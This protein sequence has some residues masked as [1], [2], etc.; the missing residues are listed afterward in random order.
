[1]EAPKNEE[2]IWSCK[3]CNEGAKM[4]YQH[5]V[6]YLFPVTKKNN[7]SEKN[8]EE[9][10]HK[11]LPPKDEEN[12]IKGNEIEEE[13]KNPDEEQGEKAD[14]NNST[15][16]VCENGP[17]RKR[18][19]TQ[20][21]ISIRLLESLTNSNRNEEEEKNPDKREIETSQK[22]RRKITEKGAAFLRG[23]DLYDSK[24]VEG[25]R[26]NRVHNVQVIA[27]LED[28]IVEEDRIE[29]GTTSVCENSVHENQPNVSSLSTEKT[30]G[31][32]KKRKSSDHI[33][34]ETVGIKINLNTCHQCHRNDKGRVVKC[35]KCKMKRFCIPCITTWY[36]GMTEEQIAMSCPICRGNCNCKSCLRNEGPLKNRV[37]DE[38]KISQE[39]K[40]DHSK[41]LL[42]T[43]LPFLK[44]FNQE[45]REEKEIEAKIQGIPVS[46]VKLPHSKFREN[47]RVFCNN[48][49]SS[50]IDFHR[51]CSKCNYNLCV[52]CCRELRA[53]R[54]QFFEEM[55]LENVDYGFQYLHGK[56]STAKPKKSSKGKNAS[57][58]LEGTTKC[59]NANAQSNRSTAVKDALAASKKKYDK[60]SLEL[61]FDD[62]NKAKPV[63][64]ADINGVIPCIRSEGCGGA[65]L[66][67]KSILSDNWVSNLL[68]HAERT[69]A[70]LGFVNTPDVSNVCTCSASDAVNMQKCASREGSEDNYLYCPDARNIQHGHLKHFQWHWTRGEPI[71]VRSVL[72]TTLGLSWEPMVM[73]RA[74]R[75]IGNR[76]LIVKA[77]DCLDWSEVDINGHHFFKVYSQGQCDDAK[78]PAMLK[79]KD[80]P[81]DGKFEQRLPRHSAEFIRALPFKEYT[82]PRDGVLNLAAKCSLRSL[83]SDLGL[84]TYIAYGRAQE[85]GYGDSVTKLHHHMSDVVNIL[86][87]TAQ[88]AHL[89]EGT[90]PPGNLK[91]SKNDSEG[92]LW[93]IFRREDALKLQEYLKRNYQDFGHYRRSPSKQAIYPIH[94]QTFYLTQEHKRKLKE[95]FGIEPWTFHQKLGEAVFIP[96]GCPHQVRNLKSCIKV[97]LDFVSPEN[98]HECIRLTGELRHLPQ[99]HR[100]K[101]DK[102][103]VRKMII[104]AVKQA[105]N[106]LETKQE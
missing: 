9:T 65:S 40:I 84:K 29:K 66:E 97:A 61:H 88:V 23:F 33:L 20:K 4:C 64:I 83:K 104:H 11:T 101:E 91:G 17:V 96:A 22:R 16:S 21:V 8:E 72:E 68:E 10:A 93:D 67:L 100:A 85:M 56:T 5:I 36:P 6:S 71:I 74:F 47:E 44:Q 24:K 105:V 45:Q 77:I 92:A 15:P 89:G 42:R 51:S 1:M 27:Q 53:G 14:L 37:N 98:V 31:K 43:I 19:N 54:L 25:K 94:D 58:D 26:R 52:I 41:K 69:M 62:H 70:M 12:L 76:L 86:V 78:Q 39:E 18:K 32:K 49:R 60:N 3:R 73:W 75:Q 87:H 103:E 34:D 50:I 106:D 13:R 82:H 99:N 48:C 81:P 28:V 57:A 102:L 38:F 59:K 63:W 7:V 95:E 55:L 46:D 80:W 79:L 35:T 90:H 30:D 2:K